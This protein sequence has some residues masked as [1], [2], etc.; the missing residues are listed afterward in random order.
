[1]ELW[2]ALV[3]PQIVG[4]LCPLP[5]TEHGFRTAFLNRSREVI[6]LSPEDELAAPLT[7]RDLE[8]LSNLPTRLTRREIAERLFVST[9]TIKTHAANLYLNEV[10]EPRRRSPPL[11][12]LTAGMRQSLG[13]P[14]CRLR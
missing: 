2:G 5:D 7:D 12:F 10:D 9:N 1:M 14:E 3:P 6:S 4:L 11:R 13:G 8:V